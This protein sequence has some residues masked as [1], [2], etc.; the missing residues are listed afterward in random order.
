MDLWLQLM[1]LR[2]LSRGFRQ[3]ALRVVPSQ[4]IDSVMHPPEIVLRR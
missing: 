2:L 3:P 1:W 4:G